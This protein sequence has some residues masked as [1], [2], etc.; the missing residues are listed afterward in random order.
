MM[1]RRD[2]QVHSQ[3]SRESE[4]ESELC[5]PAREINKKNKKKD[6]NEGEIRGIR[7]FGVIR[8][9]LLWHYKE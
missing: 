6:F 8:K 2:K 3:R 7:R 9:R 5:K 4:R 1:S